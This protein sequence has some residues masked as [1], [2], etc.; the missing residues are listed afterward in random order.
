[1]DREIVQ[2]F[3]EGE[4]FGFMPILFMKQNVARDLLSED[5]SS[6]A[7]SKVIKKIKE[8]D[9]IYGYESIV[10]ELEYELIISNQKKKLCVKKIITFKE[11]EDILNSE[12]RISVKNSLY[13]D[14]NDI[15]EDLYEYFSQYD[16]VEF[17]TV[18]GIIPDFVTT[19]VKRL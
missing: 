12:E 5:N 1:M 16:F 10:S 11:F 7:F 18:N 14:T 17:F 4:N 6:R 3:I 8:S 15:S 19:D 13:V 9:Q 2:L